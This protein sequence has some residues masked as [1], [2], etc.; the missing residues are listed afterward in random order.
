MALT[1]RGDAC[2]AFCIEGFHGVGSNVG[3]RVE[4]V[5]A[6]ARR[7]GDA[8]LKRNA[9]AEVNTDPI[10]EG[11]CSCP[12]LPV[13]TCSLP[14]RG[15]ASAR[16]C[17]LA[18]ADGGRRDRR[19]LSTQRAMPLARPRA[20]KVARPSRDRDG[21]LV[22]EQLPDAGLLLRWQLGDISRQ[23][24]THGHA[25]L[26]CRALADLL[27]PPLEVLELVDLLTLRFPVHGPGIGDHVGDRILLASQIGPVGETVVEDAIE[28][29]G[30]ITE[31]IVGV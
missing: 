12:A 10:P 23:V 18:R 5:D 1:G 24:A 20:R 19:G 7:P 26:D 4:I 29:I 14:A 27:K 9:A 22:V 13:G 21:A 15:T 8:V 31:A 11:H 30:L 16:P 6:M 25:A 3:L 2:A 28:A 17:P